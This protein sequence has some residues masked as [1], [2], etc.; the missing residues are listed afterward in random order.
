MVRHLVSAQIGEDGNLK[1]CS[2]IID[3]GSS[4]IVASTR[5][6]EK[7]NLPTLVSLAFIVRKYSDKVLCNVV[8][9]EATHILLRRPWQFDY[10]VTHDGVTNKFSFMHNGQKVQKY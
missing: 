5:L 7:L 1:L 6:V 4:A 9:M 10:K 2:I 3:G 8:P